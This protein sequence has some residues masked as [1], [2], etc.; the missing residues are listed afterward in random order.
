MD[1]VDEGGVDEWEVLRLTEEMAGAGR[2]DS[3][4]RR[5]SVTYISVLSISSVIWSQPAQ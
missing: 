5:R 2:G 1:G 3:G 4:S